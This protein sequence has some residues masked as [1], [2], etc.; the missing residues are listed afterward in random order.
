MKEKVLFKMDSEVRVSRR[1]SH[2]L[3]VSESQLGGSTTL[4]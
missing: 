4:E 1:A 2:E 3:L